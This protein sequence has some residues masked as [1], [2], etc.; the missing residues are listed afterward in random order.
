MIKSGSQTEKA[1][2]IEL[3]VNV[4]KAGLRAVGGQND[5]IYRK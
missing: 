4:T 1:S 5:R 2:W 3:N